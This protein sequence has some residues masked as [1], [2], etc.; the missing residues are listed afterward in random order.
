[1]KKLSYKIVKY[2]KIVKIVVKIIANYRGILIV[3]I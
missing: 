2:L 1:M 3:E